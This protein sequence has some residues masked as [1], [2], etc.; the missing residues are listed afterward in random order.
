MTLA[1]KMDGTRKD[2]SK[3]NNSYP[4]RQTLP[5]ISHPLRLLA[6]WLQVRL[7]SLYYL[8]KQGEQNGTIARVEG[9]ESN[10]E[11]NIMLQVILSKK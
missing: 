6:P 8:Q 4:E 5:V 9:L 11:K 1:G 2:Y 10:R 7:D 3:C